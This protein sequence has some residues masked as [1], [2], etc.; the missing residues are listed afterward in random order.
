[1]ETGSATKVHLCMQ[2]MLMVRLSNQTLS[3]LAAVHHLITSL[4]YALSIVPICGMS[5]HRRSLLHLSSSCACCK[6]LTDLSSQ[7]QCASSSCAKGN[8]LS[9]KGALSNSCHVGVTDLQ[10]SQC[11]QAFC[12][13]SQGM[14]CSISLGKWGVNAGP[15]CPHSAKCNSALP[16]PTHP[17]FAAGMKEC[18]QTTAG[19]QTGSS[20]T[21]ACSSCPCTQTTTCMVPSLTRSTHIHCSCTSRH[22]LYLFFGFLSSTCTPC[23]SLATWL[24]GP[25]QAWCCQ[26]GSLT[27]HAAWCHACCTC[28]G[29]ARQEGSTTVASQL[30]CHGLAG[31]GAG[32]ILHCDGPPSYQGCTGS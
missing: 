10:R 24:L 1:M 16:Q 29:S 4:C 27:T 22:S 15:Q 19:T 2:P 5:S 28:T 13:I 8:E 9:R 32:C 31:N 11:F 6:F 17:C 23:L 21:V 7:I 26:C 14:S 25:P 20:P 30:F 3:A 12:S 18:G